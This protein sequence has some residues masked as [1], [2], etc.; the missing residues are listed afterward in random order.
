M[1]ALA[2]DQLRSYV[3]RVERL[4]EEIKALNDDKSDVYKEARANGFD[5][6]VLRKVVAERKLDAHDR[7]ERDTIF[8]MYWSAIH[9][10]PH[11]HVH[12]EA[13]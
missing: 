6:K 5:V 9:G 10:V 13:A 4:E 3:E 11:V 2:A 12:E 1:T 8:D 7:D